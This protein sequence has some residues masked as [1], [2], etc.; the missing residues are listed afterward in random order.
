M[1][2][3]A[4]GHCGACD[5]AACSTATDCDVGECEDGACVGTRDQV[6]FTVTLAG[7]HELSNDDLLAFRE[8]VATVNKVPLSSVVIVGI[9]TTEAGL[10]IN[11]LI[12]VDEGGSAEDVSNT[13]RD[14]AES[15]ALADQLAGSGVPVEPSQIQVDP[16][17]TSKAATVSVDNSGNLVRISGQQSNGNVDGPDDSSGSGA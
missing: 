12:V 17:T 2:C 13:W 3:A 10:T 9:Q 4:D 15:G 6:R 8:V 11:G 1:V 5:A 14:N 7:V 16:T